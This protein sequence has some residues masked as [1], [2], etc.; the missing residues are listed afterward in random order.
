MVWQYINFPILATKKGTFTY[1]YSN[2]GIGRNQMMCCCR[3]QIASDYMKFSFN[4]LCLVYVPAPSPPPPSPP[5]PPFFLIPGLITTRVHSYTWYTGVSQNNFLRQK[6]LAFI[7][8]EDLSKP[9]FF[10]RFAPVH[11]CNT[12]CRKMLSFFHH[13]TTRE[14]FR[15]FLSSQLFSPLLNECQLFM[16]KDF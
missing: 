13:S 6:Y 9:P 7:F 14:S 16:P 12:F 1:S 10:C 3:S 8:F 11:F 5:A 15:I 4:P 2:P